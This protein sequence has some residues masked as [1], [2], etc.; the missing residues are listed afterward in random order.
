MKELIEIS[1]YDKQNAYKGGIEVVGRKKTE[2]LIDEIL[3]VAD[4]NVLYCTIEVKGV[5]NESL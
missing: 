3:S 4:E 5:L 2:D 1:C